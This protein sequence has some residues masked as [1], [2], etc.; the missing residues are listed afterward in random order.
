MVACRPPPLPPPPPGPWVTK[1]LPTAIKPPR[2]GTSPPGT[3]R[4]RMGTRS[5]DLARSQVNAPSLSPSHPFP[6]SVASQGGGEGG[7]GR[8]RGAQRW[9][10]QGQDD[11]LGLAKARVS[12]GTAVNPGTEGTRWDW[13]CTF[14]ITCRILWI[15]PLSRKETPRG[16]QWVREPRPL[17]GSEPAPAGTEGKHAGPWPGVTRVPQSRA[18]PL[19]RGTSGSTLTQ[20][21]PH[22]RCQN[23]NLALAPAGSPHPP[24]K[25]LPAAGRV[26]TGAAPRPK[27]SCDTP[28]GGERPAGTPPLPAGT[29][30]PMGQ[31]DTG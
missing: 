20:L 31:G 25:E 10:A 17:S 27:S 30:A 5:G 1:V 9:P 18:Q 15:L 14:P 3:P 8:A 6:C 2:A 19:S 13:P 24:G 28:A 4:R 21:P 11:S 16:D 12:L 22:P 7:G 29:G 23:G 26:S